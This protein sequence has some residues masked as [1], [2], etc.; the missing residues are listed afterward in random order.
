VK[1]LLHIVDPGLGESI[2]MALDHA[3]HEVSVL[4]AAGVDE[5]SV[6]QD[7]DAVILDLAG[8]SGVE[9]LR[10]LHDAHPAVGR[11]A[12]V[13]DAGPAALDARRAGA[14][15]ILTRPFDVGALERSLAIATRRSGRPPVDPGLIAQ[16]RRSRQ[17]LDRLE[18]A[19][20]SE[21][22]LL[23]SGPLGSGRTR[24]ARFVHAASGRSEGTLVE[25]SCGKLGVGDGEG[26]FFGWQGS[27]TAPGHVQMAHRGTLLLEDVHELP[28][29]LQDQLVH[30]LQERCVRPVGATREIPID[31]RVVATTSA[32]L[33]ECV[34]SGSFREDLRLRLGVLEIEIPPLCERRADIPALADQF[35]E[36]AA[37]TLGGPRAVLDPG[38]VAAL[39]DRPLPGNLLELDAL[40]RR[41]HTIYRGSPIP[42]E[43][44]D[45]PTASQR[46]PWP[47]ADFDL[48][49]LEREA[50]ARSLRAAGGN[51]SKAA[52]ALGISTRTLRAK[53]H[54]Y[55]LV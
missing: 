22:T 9:L 53:L 3:G 50:I 16:D 49:R 43:E 33:K 14:D 2:A 18:T 24:M 46:T 11:L 1:I 39:C 48:R 34:G 23:L 25:V 30:T 52:R 47:V 42:I 44:I 20:S 29:P 19:A 41:A 38:A 31:V 15:A 27:R 17:L 54:R 40:M 12:I 37:R 55:E 10:G 45:D 7:A 4:D 26:A 36:R 8:E 5:T 35:L 21:A 28:L 32:D 13:R 51:R 6:P